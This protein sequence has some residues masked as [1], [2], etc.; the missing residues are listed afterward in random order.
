MTSR[1]PGISPRASSPDAETRYQCEPALGPALLERVVDDV[2]RR[3][4]GRGQTEVFDALKGHL[5]SDPGGVPYQELSQQLGQSNRRW[6]PLVAW[7]LST[8][9]VTA[10]VLGLIAWLGD[11]NE[12]PIK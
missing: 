10:S 9:V 2:R 4:A 11:R 5:S 7:G 12:E 6:L 3:Y 8:V 1:T